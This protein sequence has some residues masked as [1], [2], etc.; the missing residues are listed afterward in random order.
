MNIR[1][2]LLVCVLA[3]CTS[4]DQPVVAS[5]IGSPVTWS[6]MLEQLKTAGPIRFEK[7]TS[8]QW[9]VPLSG[10]LNLEHPKAIEAGLKDGPEAIEI[11]TYALKH[12]DKGTFLV[13]SGVSEHFAITDGDTGVSALVSFAMNM[14]ELKLERSTK[15]ISVEAGGVDGVFLTHIHMDHIMGL[16][17][18]PSSTQVYIGPGDAAM[19]SF[20]NSLTRSTT[21]RLLSAQPQLIEWQFDAQGVIDVFGDGSLFAI[22]VPGHTPGATAYIARTPNGPELMIG[23]A[24]HT[25]WGWENRVESGTY[26][27][28][29]QQAAIS[30]NKLYKLVDSMPKISVHPGHQVLQ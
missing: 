13:D 19:K 2:L 17:D 23:D 21:N 6:A 14:D 29:R 25:R 10:L 12:P 9:Q 20:L 8:A 1:I 15:S 7:H 5:S 4:T 3:G 26:S 22:H 11:Y 24:T 18:L 27:V 16:I 30:L 28:D